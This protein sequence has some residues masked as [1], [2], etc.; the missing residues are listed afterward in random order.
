MRAS[1]R[2]GLVLGLAFASGLP[3][4]APAAADRLDVLRWQARPV[5]VFAPSAADPRLA[6]QAARF[7]AQRAG[8]SERHMVVLTVT[9]AADPLRRRLNVAAD[10]F[11]V[12]LVG[13]DGH[14]AGRWSAPVDPDALFALIDKM[15]M[16]RDEM[17]RDEMRR[18]TGS[19]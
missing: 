12:L 5:V 2:A 7:A 11:R 10:R 6:D 1:S 16:R 3:F 8:L 9:D 17:R 15:P 13:K 19:N 18:G 4:A 14:V